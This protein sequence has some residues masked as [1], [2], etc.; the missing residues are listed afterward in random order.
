MR[1]VDSPDRLIVDLPNTIISTATKERSFPANRLGIQQIRLGQFQNRP[2][3]TRIVLDIDQE[4]AD[5]ETAYDPSVKGVR[6]VPAG[7]LAVIQ[8]RAGN[9]LAVRLIGDRLIF[10]GD[11][12]LQ[13]KAEFTGNNYKVT[14]PGISLPAQTLSGPKLTTKGPLDRLRIFQDPG[15]EVSAVLALGPGIQVTKAESRKNQFIIQFNKGQIGQPTGEGPL[16]VIDPGHGGTDPGAM[17]GGR[18][19]KTLNFQVAQYLGQILS[20]KGY[21]VVFTR[22]DDRFIPLQG[23]VDIAEQVNANI[24]V[25]IHHNAS[26][27]TATD[28]IQT[29]YIRENSHRL[30]KI[31][32]RNLISR[33]G[34]PDRGLRTARFYVIR[35]TTMPA[36]LVEMGYITN[37]AELALVSQAPHQRLAAESIARALDEYFQK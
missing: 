14:F 7:Q 21:R 29:Y 25:S 34:Q 6:L 35:K 5:W 31:V 28:G 12:P 27:N 36:I 11:G 1:R 24:F 15:S 33:V 13:A 16:V 19:E 4:V 18:N 20:Q 23:R 32:H 2:P 26:E 3:I 22:E 8:K 10:V 17:A 37:P 30:A 9:L